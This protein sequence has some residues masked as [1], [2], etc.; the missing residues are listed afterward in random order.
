MPQRYN[1]FLLSVFALAL[2]G[3]AMLSTASAVLAFQHAGDSYFYLRR[4]LLN[5]VIPG[6]FLFFA[7][8]F[9]PYKKLRHFA[10]PLLCVC[11]VLLAMLFAPSLGVMKNG[12]TRWLSLGFFSFQ[13]S[14]LLKLA[15]VIYLSA[16]FAGR[17]E[18]TLQSAQAFIPFL[19]VMGAVSALL[20]WQPDLG[21]LGIISLTALSLY[22]AAGARIAHLVIVMLCGLCALFIFIYGFGYELDRIAVFLNPHSDV[23]GSGYQIYK[24]RAAIDAG[25]AWGIGFGQSQRK[26]SGYLPEPMGDSIFAIIAEELGF[27]G[28]AAV[29]GLFIWFG[30][31]GFSV[32]KNASDS[33]GSLLAAGVTSWV[34]I[35]AFIN[36]GAISGMLPL[37][38]VPLPFMSYGGTSLAVLL[39]ACGMVY[40]IQK[41]SV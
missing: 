12:A 31:Q 23:Q 37:T 38:G 24:A 36:I 9:F 4:Q 10:L 39:T 13:P 7:A 8:S 32:A 11:T 19:A 14:E 3:L 5:G 25:G 18:K 34:L 20:A 2:F 28:V 1:F 6:V 27:A 21:T 15:S 26:L 22:F 30:W 17:R 35:Q 41:A 33:F 16:L 40:N 29:T